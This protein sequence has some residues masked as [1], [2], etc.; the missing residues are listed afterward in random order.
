MNQAGI[1]V[2]MELTF[3]ELGWGGLQGRLVTNRR[4]VGHLGPWA[5]IELRGATGGA[6]NNIRWNKL[7]WTCWEGSNEGSSLSK[8]PGAGQRL[9]MF[10][11][12]QGGEWD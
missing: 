3:L 8:G 11:E 2:F 9:S 12:Q 1:P 7:G 6:L 4:L 10:Q 5:V